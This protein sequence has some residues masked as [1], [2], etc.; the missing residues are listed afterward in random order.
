[1]STTNP[2]DGDQ[3][4]NY[5]AG[6]QWIGF[7]G[8]IYDSVIYQTPTTPQ[9]KYQLG[10]SFLRMGESD[11]ARDLITEA[12]EEG[13]DS[14]QVRFHWVLAILSG[15]VLDQ[16]TD[17]DMSALADAISLC[18]DDSDWARGIRLVTRLLTFTMTVGDGQ[19]SGNTQRSHDDLDSLVIQLEALPEYHNIAIR[20]HMELLLDGAIHDRLHVKERQEVEKARNANA[21]KGRLWKFFEPKPQPPRHYVPAKPLWGP[22]TYVGIVVASASSLL[23]VAW[24]ATLLSGW[25]SMLA[26]AVTGVGAILAARYGTR[27]IRA[28][29]CRR[30]LDR[31][32]APRS[33]YA[34]IS[35]DGYVASARTTAGFAAEVSALFEEYTREYAPIDST[36]WRWATSAA[37]QW[38]RNEIVRVYRET[39]V[40]ASEIKWLVRHRIEQLRRHYVEGTLWE[41]RQRFRVPQTT[42]FATFAGTAIGIAGGLTLVV[43]AITS[44]PFSGIIATLLIVAGAVPAAIGILRI[45]RAKWLY[46]FKQQDRKERSDQ[47]FEAYDRWREV[48]ADRPHGRGSGSVA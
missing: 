45:L 26:A 20:R 13:Y 5:N 6:N 40:Q 46:Q 23:G 14:P 36:H 1:M 15:R 2:H 35:P 29:D 34:Y 44:A 32:Y 4:L 7:Q 17:D 28:T 22:A 48:L 19:S 47:D 18:R 24:L 8:N 42:M 16:I 30:L 27:W 33:P 11:K 31:R 9:H 3:F 10:V 21:R 12:I 43:L 25:Q 39:R 37:R 38:F 41:Y